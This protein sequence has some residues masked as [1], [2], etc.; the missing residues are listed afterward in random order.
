MKKMKIIIKYFLSEDGK[1]RAVAAGLE[2]LCEQEIIL[3]DAD[4][5]SMVDSVL[6][7]SDADIADT[8]IFDLRRRGL[9]VWESNRKNYYMKDFHYEPLRFSKE[10]W[11]GFLKNLL[12][13]Y[14]LSKFNVQTGVNLYLD[15]PISTLAD[16]RTYEEK[17]VDTRKKMEELVVWINDEYVRLGEEMHEQAK[18]TIAEIGT[19]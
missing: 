5:A 11:Q 1:K 18:K 7:V 16:L 19:A 15:E 10:E 3:D 13:L 9:I 17:E 2:D 4:A 12:R 6:E 14:G 8:M